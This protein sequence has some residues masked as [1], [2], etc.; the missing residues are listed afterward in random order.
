VPQD[1]QVPIREG[2]FTW[3]ASPTDAKL[4]GSKCTDCGEVTFP[5]Q[6]SC[7]KC[8][9]LTTQPIALSRRGRLHTYTIIHH[10]TPGYQGP[11]PYTIGLVE[12]PEGLFVLAPVTVTD[13]QA[14]RVG[15]DLEFT[16]ETQFT[17]EK[18]AQVVAYKFRPV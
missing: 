2:L 12:L 7:P 6:P 13:P 4:L 18:G 14:I 10:Q 17:D 8:G 1:T 9:T 5:Q 15:M 11:V 3:P 16:L